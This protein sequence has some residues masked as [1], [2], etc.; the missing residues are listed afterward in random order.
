MQVDKVREGT[1]YLAHGDT[2][3]PTSQSQGLHDHRTSE[4]ATIGQ[5]HRFHSIH[6]LKRCNNSHLGLSTYVWLEP[7]PRGII[8]D[9]RHNQGVV[10]ATGATGLLL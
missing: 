1:L 6:S 7:E 4:T 5:T 9:R 2:T 10:A 3:D 8:L